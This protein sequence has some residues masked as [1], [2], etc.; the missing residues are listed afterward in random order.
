[1]PGDSRIMADAGLGK[2][3]STV[4]TLPGGYTLGEVRHD[5]GIKYRLFCNASP[6]QINPGWGFMRASGCGA[7]SIALTSTLDVAR[8]IG[9]GVVHHATVPTAYYFWGAVRGYLASG[10][11][12]GETSIS[13]G[14]PMSL[15]TT[16]CFL[17]CGA[18]ISTQVPCGYVLA[19]VTTGHTGTG[20]TRTGSVYVAFE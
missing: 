9:G 15:Q 4:A 14:N 16:G 19:T 17:G 6:D 11:I 1:M 10:V 20:G 7:Y 13:S 2:V 3:S 5:G 12:G 8:H 18:T